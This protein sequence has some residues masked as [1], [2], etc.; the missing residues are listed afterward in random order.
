MLQRNL[1]DFP[2]L[3]LRSPICIGDQMQE[4]TALLAEGAIKPGCNNYTLLKEFIDLTVE[5]N[6]N[7]GLKLETSIIC[8]LFLFLKDFY[9]FIHERHRERSRLYAGSLTW[10]S[11]LGL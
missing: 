10:D 1:V 5:Q 2:S 9:L 4:N 7:T 8:F 3:L 11:I 6:K